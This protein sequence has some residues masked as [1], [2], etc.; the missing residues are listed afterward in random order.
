MTHGPIPPM[1][2]QLSQARGYEESEEPNTPKYNGI[3]IAW[4]SM[5]TV[6]CTVI[7]YNWTKMLFSLST[8]GPLTSPDVVT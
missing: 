5:K 7:W 8:F 4:I 1:L 2:Y 3:W 6:G